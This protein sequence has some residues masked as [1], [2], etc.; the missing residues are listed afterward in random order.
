M[1]RVH[2]RVSAAKQCVELSARVYVICGRRAACGVLEFIPCAT[3]SNILVKPH[4]G[5]ER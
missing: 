1:L 5:D 2:P 3:V 4:R